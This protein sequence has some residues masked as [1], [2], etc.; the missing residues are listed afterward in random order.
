MGLLKVI[1]S[2][3]AFVVL[4]V[5]GL[6]AYLWFTDYEAQATITEKGT[7]DEGPFV[8]ITPRLV[9]ADVK[10]H[11]TSEQASFICIGYKVAYRIQTGFFQV[12]DDRDAL[13]YDSENGLQN[14]GAAIRCTASNAGG[15]ILGA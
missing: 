2:I 10:H 7:D 13:V 14:T 9:G 3:V 12:F 15:G 5:V 8:V 4:A 6:G 1:F 11:V